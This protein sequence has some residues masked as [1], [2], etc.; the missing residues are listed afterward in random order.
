MEWIDV[1]VN[2]ELLSFLKKM[3]NGK[4]VKM[5]LTGKYSK[6]RNLS[7]TEIKAIKDV[8]LAYDVL[9]NE[10]RLTEKEKLLKELKGE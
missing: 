8:L 10:K 9:K 3:V 2:D 5:R 7:S 6:T 4:S 1:S